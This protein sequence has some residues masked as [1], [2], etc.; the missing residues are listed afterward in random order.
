P[1]EAA[2]LGGHVGGGEAD[3]GGPLPDRIAPVLDAALQRHRVATELPQGLQD[4][5]LAADA[6]GKLPDVVDGDG[7]GNLDPGLSQDHGGG[8]VGTA[9]A[10][11]EGAHAA[12]GGGVGVGAEDDLPR[13]H[14]VPV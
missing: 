3:V 12:V 5:V 8:D 13:L 7:V 2:E 10:D 9:Q 11:G 4:H 6:E 1:V 14:E